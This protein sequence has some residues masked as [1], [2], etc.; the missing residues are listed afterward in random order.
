MLIPFQRILHKYQIKPK[1]IIHVG[2]HFG[3]E[4]KDYIRCGIRDIIFIEP[5]K[6]AFRILANNFGNKPG[7]KLVNKALGATQGIGTMFTET[8]NSG[9]SNSLLQ[10]DKHL[11]QHK[12]VVFNGNEE[13][14]IDT[15]DS[16]D[17]E[18]KQYNILMMDVQG[19]EGEVL[20]GGVN[21]LKNIDMVYSEVNRDSTYK[22]NALIGELDLL[23]KD[24]RRVETL[25][26]SAN[27][28][29]G[30]AVWIKRKI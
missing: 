27:L 10:P 6:P 30:D 17:L 11:I 19:Y 7:V 28:S 5:C 18:G 4:Y 22:G 15:L 20:K 29:W 16:L 25:W 1:G 23:L 21:T 3:E 14:E 12:E 9:Q 26:A 8:H 2:G 13:V 24:F